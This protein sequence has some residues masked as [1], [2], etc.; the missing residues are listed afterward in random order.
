MFNL[1]VRAGF[2]RSNRRN[3]NLSSIV[4][5]LILPQMLQKHNL[6]FLRV[7]CNH[8]LT[9][10]FS[11][12]V[13]MF[14]VTLCIQ[15]IFLNSI[16]E[17]FSSIDCVCCHFSHMACVH[18]DQQRIRFSVHS[19]FDSVRTL[20]YRLNQQM[21]IYASSS[22]VYNFAPRDPSFNSLCGAFITAS[23]SRITSSKCN[24]AHVEQVDK[25]IRLQLCFGLLHCNCTYQSHHEFSLEWWIFRR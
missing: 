1:S 2:E 20:K 18:R 24:T 25:L 21:L 19:I 9:A 16:Q 22:D 23:F 4:M 14:S 11:F 10:F 17:Q 12:A 6:C 7:Q 13:F 3:F 15:Q 8:Q 5:L